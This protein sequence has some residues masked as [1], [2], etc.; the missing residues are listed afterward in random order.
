MHEVEVICQ[1]K[2]NG[3]MIPIR[4]KIE[5]NEQQM[6][7]FNVKRYKPLKS[8]I[9]FLEYECVIEVFKVEKLVKLRYIINEHKWILFS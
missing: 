8:C 9:N 6:Q 1:I 4:M 5:D 2:I 3:S 7:I